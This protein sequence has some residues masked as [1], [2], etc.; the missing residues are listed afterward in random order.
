MAF[1]QLSKWLEQ[2]DISQVHKRSYSDDDNQS[3]EKNF[4]ELRFIY[5]IFC[6]VLSKRQCTKSENIKEE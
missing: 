4:N 5:F 1:G 2:N 3:N 6:L